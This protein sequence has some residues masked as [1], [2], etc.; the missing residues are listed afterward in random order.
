MQITCYGLKIVTR[1]GAETPPPAGVT[2]LENALKRAEKTFENKKLKEARQIADTA[3]NTFPQSYCPALARLHYLCADAI[4]L[5]YINNK[6]KQNI[7]PKEKAQFLA[8][9]GQLDAIYSTLLSKQPH[10]LKPEDYQCWAQSKLILHDTHDEYPA[11]QEKHLE[12]ARNILEGKTAC[13]FL[14]LRGEIFH[15][16][17]V[18]AQ[19]CDRPPQDIER[20]FKLALSSYA[21]L[22]HYRN[23]TDS[24]DER[25]VRRT[26]RDNFK[27]TRAEY[28]NWLSNSDT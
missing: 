20:Y 26:A 24:E 15:A 11:T 10:T 6:E 17:A 2:L 21:K 8:H 9:L 7:V 23:G 27:N 5:L 18:I 28:E 1:F 4:F 14:S 12:R 13:E 16:S 22:R 3:V 19:R 25:L